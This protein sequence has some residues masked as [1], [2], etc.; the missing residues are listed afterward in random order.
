MMIRN[1][2]LA[3]YEY[4]HG[5]GS[6]SDPFGE[7]WKACAR[8]IADWLD[9]IPATRSIELVT[10]MDGTPESGNVTL[11]L[12]ELVRHVFLEDTRS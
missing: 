1:L 5:H 12:P 7:G 3:N 9:L 10:A 11:T 2:D 6:A 4:L 8:S